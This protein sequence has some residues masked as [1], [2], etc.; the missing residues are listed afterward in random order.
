MAGILCAAAVL[1]GGFVMTDMSRSTAGEIAVMCSEDS[2]GQALPPGFAREFCQHLRNALPSGGA[3]GGRVD[4]TLRRTSQYGL[5]AT[6]TTERAGAGRK[7]RE[8]RLSI[9]DSQLRPAMGQSLAFPV[10]GM[11]GLT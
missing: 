8:F 3:Q 7:T 9:R 10:A 1:A 5:L 6:I 4:V 11:L 2:A